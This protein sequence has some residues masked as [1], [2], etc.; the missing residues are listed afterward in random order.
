[1]EK[2]VKTIHWIVDNDVNNLLDN[3]AIVEAAE[4][5][6]N[7]E[8]VAFPTETVYGLGGNAYSDEAIEKIFVAKGRPADNPLIIHIYSETQ[9]N[10][11]VASVPELAKPLIDAFWP[12]PLTLILPKGKKVSTKAT[13]GLQTVAIRM[14]NHPVALAL[15]EKTNLPI[16]APSANLSGKPSPTTAAH[17]LADLDNKIAGIVDGS[18][19]GIGVESTVVHMDDDSL[20]VLRPGS[21]TVEQLASVVGYDAIR[22]TKQQTSERPTSPGMKYT[23]YAPNAPLYIVNGSREH[24]QELVKQQQAQGKR[25][26]VLTTEEYADAYKADL[27]IACGQREALAS[28]ATG[29]YAALRQFDAEKV[30]VIISES[31]PKVGIGVAI[32]NRLEKAAIEIME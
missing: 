18:Q 13:A 3:E 4:Q 6:Q 24:I 7:N 10:E 12:G 15:L 17:V 25:V 5:L 32:M 9:L 16:A 19:T 11:L 1:M 14:P 26:G 27:V 2:L 29:L 31:F 23:H 30:D 21:I 28:V 22:S 8:V 20:T